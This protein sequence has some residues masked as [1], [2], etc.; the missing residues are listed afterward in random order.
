[1]GIDINIFRKEKG[2]DPEKVL[3]SEKARF[4]G[5]KGEDNVREIINLDEEWRKS[6]FV[7][8]QFAKEFNQLNKTIGLKKKEGKDCAEDLAKITE[9]KTKKAELEKIEEKMI[10]ELQTKLKTVG[11][12]VHESVKIDDN[13]DNNEVIKVWGNIPNIKVNGTLGALPHNK[14]LALI[15]G[16]DPKRGSRIAGHRGYFLKGKGAL[17]NLA[18]IN[19]GMSFLVNKGYTPIQTPYFM[20]KNIMGE[21]CQLSDFDDQLYKVSTGKNDKEMKQNENEDEDDDKYL[22]AT[23][24]QPI[25][26][27]YYNEV[28]DP[29]ELPI[30][31]GGYSTCFRK[32]AGAHGKDA[33]GIFRVH[34][35]EKIEQF[36]LSEPEKSWEEHE[37]MLACSEEFYQ[38]LGLPY[39]VVSIVSGALNDAAAKKYDLEAWFPG[40]DTYRELVSCSNCTDFQS[41]GLNIRMAE[42]KGEEKKKGPT[43]VHMLNS[44]LAAT[45]RTLC[46]ILENYQTT[47]GV[48]VPK[49]LIPYMNTDFIPYT[50]ELTKDN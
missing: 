37:K 10:N 38:S 21:T 16:Y 19:Y 47:E 36:V 23:S 31:F 41:R 25:S 8:D 48:R 45:Q 1:M 18:L 3:K 6:L 22:I 29:S 7:K 9:I 35:F 44:T 4:R 27:Y 17:L 32:E 11:N 26:S 43:Y 20:K 46:C 12:I 28:I 34:Q 40:Y 33:W 49:V 14:I 5:E 39:R 2:G 42:K 50:K 24:E 13:E 30:R 15:D